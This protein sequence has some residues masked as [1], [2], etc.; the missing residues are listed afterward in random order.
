MGSG[1]RR[2]RMSVS[3]EKT[4]VGQGSVDRETIDFS[5][6]GE[7]TEG[8]F[9]S[10]FLQNYARIVAVLVRLLG[11][12][13]QAEELADEVFLKLYSHPLKP[14]GQEGHNIGGWLY[15][16]ATR[17]GIDALRAATRRRRYEAEAAANA[18]EA[19]DGPD[20]LDQALR[21]EKCQRVRAVLARLKPAQAQLLIMRHSDL[22]YKEMALAL[23]VKPSSVGT[24]LA[25]AE[26][27]FEKH[28]RELYGSEE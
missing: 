12:R 13:A 28:Y 17:L 18:H 2:A 3:A 4:E 7:E 22:S 10:V 6:S 25:R 5:R 19:D 20:P 27:E 8:A 26:D 11:D 9:E 1:K 15:R 24:L 21:R 16:T 23:E 14:S